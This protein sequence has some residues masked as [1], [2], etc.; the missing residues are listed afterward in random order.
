MRTHARARRFL[1]LLI[2]PLIAAG[3]LIGVGPGAAS[4][5]ACVSWTGV[6]PTAPGS[7]GFLTAAAVVSSCNAWAVG[8]YNN[9]IDYQ[10]LIEH[11][12]GSSWVQ[13][14]SPAPGTGNELGAV[15]A[16]SASNAWAVGVY[17]NPSP[18]QTLIEHWNGSSWAQQPSPDPGG[19]AQTNILYGV[20]A[21]SAGNAW[22]VGEYSNGTDLLSL[23]EHWDGTA[24]AQVPSPS[25]GTDRNLLNGVAATSAKDAWAV[26]YYDPGN[27]GE[28]DYQT[29]IEHWDGTSW[30]VVPS[31]S[32]GGPDHANWLY[33]VAATSPTNAWAV[34]DFDNGT[35]L[36]TLIEHWNGSRWKRV[37]APSPGSVS[38]DL[39]GVT[40]LSAS[41][42]WAV[43]GSYD[44]GA[45]GGQ[46]LIEH[47]NGTAWAQVPS[48]DPGAANG[49][50]LF[51]V[52]GASA[53]NIWAVGYYYPD[54][55]TQQPVALH[56][57]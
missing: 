18:G 13:Q 50:N 54:A 30:T 16:T 24:W 25:V 49:N 47:W 5:A 35:S 31:P 55:S 11:W 23:I 14:P 34:G 7:P 21:A 9:G 41:N 43:G 17:V 12:N 52:A 2:A 42:V 10:T 6:Q 1:R 53:R 20:A 38:N 15:A 4:A 44:G 29:L 8:E 19:P 22:A 33:S 46:T 3:A 32:P 45:D 57:C 36:Q 27:P 48:P 28:T 26:G 51:G 39:H 37:A 40:A 56:C